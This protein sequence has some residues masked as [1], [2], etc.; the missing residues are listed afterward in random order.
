MRVGSNRGLTLL[1]LLITLSIAII[2]TS[3]GLPWWTQTIA[4]NHRIAATNNIV[5]LVQRARSEAIQ[6]G[7]EVVLC[8]D[9]GHGDCLDADDL[10]PEGYVMF[11]NVPA[12]RPWRATEPSHRLSRG[13]WPA[14]MQVLVNRAGLVFR[15]LARRST[16]A[17]FRICDGRGR[18]PPRAVIISPTGRPRTSDRL[19]GGA[20]IPCPPAHE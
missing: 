3:F 16:N 9:N 1:E 10:W 4:S 18:V 17:T 2:V 13:V 15:P 19:A 11:I 6:T 20:P 8:P 14:D 5:G 7:Q 12:G